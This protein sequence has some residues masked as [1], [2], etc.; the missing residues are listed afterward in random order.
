VKGVTN[1]SNFA[2]Q[3]KKIRKDKSLRQIDVATSLGLAQTT[4]ANY[5]QG[6][7]FPDEKTLSQIAKFFNVTLDYLLARTDIRPNNEDIMYMDTYLQMDMHENIEFSYLQKKYFEFVLNGEKHLATQLIL[8]SARNK[9]SAKDI[10][11]Y[12]LE[13][14]LKEV[15]YLWEMNIIDISQEHYFSNVTQEIMSK[16][17][18]Y[19]NIR[20]KNGHSCVSLSINGEFHNIGVHMVT[21]LLDVQGWNTYY[22]GSD[23]PTQNVIRAVKDRKATMLVISATMSFNLDSVTNLIKA[24]RS[25]KGCGDVKI[26]VGGRAFNISKHLW[27]VVGAD[28]YAS[29]AQEAVEI[30]EE[31]ILKRPD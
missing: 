28:G 8:D 11:F 16:L 12:I 6:T 31:L 3:L 2:S 1:I 25:S 15:G 13:R 14:S 24:V 18:P 23:I 27:K 10:Y 9:F 21:D 17:Y 19:F 7:R 4:I 5:E 22:L 29:T 20:E 30:A 26:M